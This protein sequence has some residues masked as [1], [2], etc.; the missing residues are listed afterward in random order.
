MA[1]PSRSDDLFIHSEKCFSFRMMMNNHDMKNKTG[2]ADYFY[3][4]LDLNKY[5]D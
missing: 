3:F 4:V 5:D 2:S 1:D